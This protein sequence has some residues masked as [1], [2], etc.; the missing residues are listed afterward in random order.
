MFISITTKCSIHKDATGGRINSKAG[1]ETSSYY[2]EHPYS[3]IPK[4]EYALE[5]AEKTLVVVFP[6]EFS[7]KRIPVLVKNIKSILDIKEQRYDSVKRDGEVII[8]DAYDPVFASSAICLLFGIKRVAMARRIKNDFDI[9]SSEISKVGTKLLLKGDVFYVKVE[10]NAKG[11]IPKDL[12]MAATSK[13]IEKSTKLNVRPGTADN[14]NRQL[15][16]FLTRTNA[17]VCIFSDHGLGGIPYG[18]YNHTILCAIFDG[19]SAISCIETIKQGFK[20][21]IIVCYKKDSEL[22]D[23]VKMTD[24]II[25]RTISKDIELEF[26]KL[27]STA[28][29]LAY[30]RS[31]MHVVENVAKKAKINHVSLPVTPLVFAPEIIDEMLNYFS[32]NKITAYTPLG[33]LEDE[34]YKTAS[35]IGIKRF[36][37]GI[38]YYKYAL[39]AKDSQ[40]RVSSKSM[41]VMIGPNNIHE[42]LDEIQGS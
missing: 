36:T 31:I 37:A 6:S 7:K 1:L 29:K 8:V 32:K 14:H 12:E 11:F 41:S 26:F 25:P 20:V 19:L 33:A 30:F 17:Y 42:I 28:D 23:L 22:A 4:M 38:N 16:T 9:I 24:K 39:P 13:I 2:Y 10:G 40:I 15:Y 18:T 21:K 5:M 35:E 27:E 34:L 3:I